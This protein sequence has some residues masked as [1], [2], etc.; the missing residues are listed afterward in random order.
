[1]TEEDKDNVRDIPELSEEEREFRKHLDVKNKLD[2]IILDITWKV[3]NKLVPTK[4]R[5]DRNL[6][7]Y[8]M[9]PEPLKTDKENPD[10]HFARCVWGNLQWDNPQKIKENMLKDI[11]KWF[12]NEI[13]DLHIFSKGHIHEPDTVIITHADGKDT[14]IVWIKFLKEKITDEAWKQ[15]EESRAGKESVVMPPSLE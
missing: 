11:N 5:I 7:K 13:K 8:D 6:I 12:N 9:V 14:P 1:M 15:Y 4:I 3:N 2:C 10:F